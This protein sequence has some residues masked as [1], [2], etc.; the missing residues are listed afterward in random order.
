MEC[1]DCN[2]CYK[3]GE[4]IIFNVCQ[5]SHVCNTYRC[6]ILNYEELENMH[7]C[8]NC[9]HWIGGGDF[10]LSCSKNYYYCSSNGFNSACEQFKRKDK[11]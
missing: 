9:E 2:Y 6:D 1:K 5:I 11:S 4:N 10:G 8:F 7:I 3:K